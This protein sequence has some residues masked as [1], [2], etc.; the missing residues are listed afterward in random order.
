MAKVLK[1]FTNMKIIE[2]HTQQEKK[3]GG[4]VLLSQIHE[5]DYFLDLFEN[6]RIKILS[7]KL[8]KKNQI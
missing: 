7:S 2:S 8:F 1:I 6:Y 4:G 3:L 5:I